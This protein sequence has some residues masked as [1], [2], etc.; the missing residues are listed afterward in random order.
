MKKR[1]IFTIVFLL[2]TVILMTACSNNVD[3]VEVDIEQAAKPTITPMPTQKP[4]PKPTLEPT[5][6]PGQYGD[7]MFVVESF[8]N[9]FPANIKQNFKY[10]KQEWFLNYIVALSDGFIYKEPSIYANQIEKIDYG[11][12][13]ETSAMIV[14]DTIGH[15]YRV[16]W[17]DKEENEFFGY[18]HN[19]IADY[20]QFLLDKAYED[21]GMLQKKVDEENSFYVSINNRNNANGFA[22]E[23]NLTDEY[24]KIIDQ[25]GVLH[26]QS[27]P[28]YIENSKSSE[29]RYICD[30]TLVEVI[31]KT[32]NLVEIY[33]PQYDE[34]FFT[35]R[36][37]LK[38]KDSDP[39][40]S[41]EKLTESIVIDRTNQNIMY[42]E[43]N[44]ET[45]EWELLTM[46]YVS[47]GTESV[48]ADPTPIGFF[49]VQKVRIQFEYPS[50]ENEGIEAGYA[51]YVIRFSGGA[52][53]HGVPLNYTK[54]KLGNIV[55]PNTRESHPSL[56][57][58]AESHMCVRNYT[59][60]AEF[61]FK[62]VEAGKAVVIVIE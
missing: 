15:W 41:I 40:T 58:K 22:P 25:Y 1:Y 55:K 52:Y 44:K 14:S 2:I 51:P 62:R 30:G 13:M 33:V 8:E 18:V 61:L 4:K 6:D 24:G 47:T 29:F 32:D 34:N 31:N 46:S 38:Y 5:P 45:D 35:P 60:H 19:S 39:K 48:Y 36:K 50:D 21:T 17:K 23:T 37:Y 10:D 28:A 16:H 56:G 49:M 27:A 3:V 59:S 12:R 26:D 42:F 57:V 7:G 20:R 54:D 9:I 11:D 43:V 53:N